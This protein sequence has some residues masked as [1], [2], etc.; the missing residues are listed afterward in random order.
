MNSM[1][2]GAASGMRRLR[3]FQGRIASLQKR[4]LSK[5]TGQ[6]SE[7]SKHADLF[8]ELYLDEFNLG[9]YNGKWSGDGPV[10]HS[11]NPATNNIIGS[12]RVVRPFSQDDCIW[13][14]RLIGIHRELS[15]SSTKPWKLLRKLSQLGET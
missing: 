2:F 4:A 9:V 8:R 3:P 15:K 14:A 6:V 10:V 11:Y 7:F 1:R 13:Q 5:Q 12:T